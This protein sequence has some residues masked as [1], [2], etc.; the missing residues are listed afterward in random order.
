MSAAADHYQVLG[1]RPTATQ[2]QITEAYKVGFSKRLDLYQL[3]VS[4]E[5]KAICILSL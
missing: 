2:E 3:F 1:L 4:V 5:G